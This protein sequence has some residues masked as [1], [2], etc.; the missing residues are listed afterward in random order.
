MKLNSDLNYRIDHRRDAII[1]AIN[2]GDLA[3]LLHDQLVRE[4]KYNRGCRLRGF[5]EGPITFNPTYKYDPGS[6]DYDTSEKHGAPAWCDRILWR[7][8][9][10]TRVN[11]LHYRRY[12]ANVSDHRPIS[13]AFSITLKTFDKETREK[14]H[15]D[16]QAEWFEEQQRLLTAVTKFYVGQALI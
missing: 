7:S 11:Q 6:D 3:S 15:A 2:A 14:A 8:R 4:I 12:E 1:A 13:A 10:A 5:S 16:L 9:V